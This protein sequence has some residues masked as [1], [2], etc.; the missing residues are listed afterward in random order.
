[1][2]IIPAFEIGLWN[3]CIFMLLC[4]LPV[5][6]VA[7]FH[8]GLFKKTDSIHASILTGMENKI[9]IFSRYY[10]GRHLRIHPLR[11]PR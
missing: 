11:S 7:L 3:A 9:L 2:S 6:L 5:P 1:M 4:L 8:E 10:L